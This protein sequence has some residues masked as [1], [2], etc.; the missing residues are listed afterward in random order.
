MTRWQ[1]A[2]REMFRAVVT[3]R[4]YS[5]EGL[6][7]REEVP[8]T[9]LGFQLVPFD[10]EGR[11]RSDV[12]GLRSRAAIDDLAKESNPDD[13]GVSLSVFLNRVRGVIQ[14][15]PADVRWCGW[16][17]A[18]SAGRTATGT[19]RWR[20]GVPAATCSPHDPGQ[21]QVPSVG[22]GRP[23]HSFAWHASVRAHRSRLVSSKVGLGLSDTQAIWGEA[24]SRILT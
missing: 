5:G 19:F 20:S 4:T 2:M 10:A 14:H 17:S 11:E 13:E 15:G 12:V 23:T 1:E 16:R 3:I 9:S 8:G 6:M 21:L 22:D 18:N 24:S 7:P